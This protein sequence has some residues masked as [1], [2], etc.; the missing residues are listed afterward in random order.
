MLVCKNNPMPCVFLSP[1]VSILHDNDTIYVSMIRE[2]F[3][4]FLFPSKLSLTCLFV[5]HHTLI[6]ARYPIAESSSMWRSL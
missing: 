5:S 4:P 1:A 3:R 2:S 6:F